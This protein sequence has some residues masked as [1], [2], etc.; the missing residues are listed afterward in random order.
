MISFYSDWENITEFE[1]VRINAI[2]KLVEFINLKFEDEVNSIMIYGSF[3]RREYR[4]ESDI[5]LVIFSKEHKDLNLI[6]TKTK[7]FLKEQDLNNF[8]K[9]GFSVYSIEGL[10]SEDREGGVMSTK[11]RVLLSKEYNLIY[12]KELPYDTLP[13]KTYEE[14]FKS[15]VNY[16][17][18]TINQN[19]NEQLAKLYLFMRYFEMRMHKRNIKFSF[20]VLK[21]LSGPG[22]LLYDCADL[23]LNQ[24]P[25][26]NNFMYKFEKKLS[27]P[28]YL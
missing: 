24:I 13:I 11:T 17:K 7:L 27:S 15:M 9:Q 28:E 26:P 21:D 22:K 6:K 18:A 20:K 14:A 2:E 19:S 25:L 3:P 10:K 4:E 16:V 8:F 23:Y 5:D 1:Q 12:G